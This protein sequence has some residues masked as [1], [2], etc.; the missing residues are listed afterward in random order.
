[1]ARKSAAFNAA[2]PIRPPSISG[3]AINSFALSGFMLPPYK[4]CTLP[5]AAAF[6]SRQLRAQL[7]VHFLRHLRR[8]RLAGADR[9]DRLVGDHDLRH[10]VVADAAPARRRAG[11]APRRWSAPLRAR[12]AFRRRKRS[13][14]CRRP[15]LRPPFAPPVHCSR[16]DRRGARSG[17][18]SH[19]GSRSRPA[20]APTLR[21]CRRRRRGPTHPAR[22]RRPACRPALS[23]HWAR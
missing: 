18:R 9:P 16:R 8:C 12:P 22:P 1:M 2:P 11:C 23:A 19:S 15:V 6:C 7:R 14:S 21:R 3:C 5:A 10:A 4:I 20:S 13:G 17:R